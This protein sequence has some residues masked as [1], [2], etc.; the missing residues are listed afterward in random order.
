MGSW[1]RAAAA[2][3]P[4]AREAR[5][6]LLG[7]YDHSGPREPCK[8]TRRIGVSL[9]SRASEWNDKVAEPQNCHSAGPCRGCPTSACAYH[10]LSIAR[11][12]SRLAAANSAIPAGFPNLGNCTGDRFRSKLRVDRL[13]AAGQRGPPPLGFSSRVRCLCE[14]TSVGRDLAHSRRASTVGAVLQPARGARGALF[15]QPGFAL[16]LVS[17]TF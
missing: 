11:R 7:P 17:F 3:H 6:Q 15:C 8:A 5:R 12:P 9:R 16:L 2:E 13:G 1:H 4:V 14:D 10:Y